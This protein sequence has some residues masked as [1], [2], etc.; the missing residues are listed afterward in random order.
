MWMTTFEVSLEVTKPQ[1]KSGCVHAGHLSRV[2]PGRTFLGDG[3]VA[4][5]DVAFR[6]SIPQNE[7]NDAAM[8]LAEGFSSLLGPE[9]GIQRFVMEMNRWA[10]IFKLGDTAFTN[11]HGLGNSLSTASDVGKMCAIVTKD[12]FV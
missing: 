2:A 9:Q 5:V 10:Q 7:G 11:P 4:R 1:P 8:V 3:L 12:P 6:F